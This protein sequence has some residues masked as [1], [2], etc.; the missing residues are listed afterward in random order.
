MP[1]DLE[2]LFGKLATTLPTATAWE[3]NC[4]FSAE[5]LPAAPPHLVT[6]RLVILKGDSGFHGP[7]GVSWR[8]DLLIFHAAKE[9][10]R[11]LALL[12]FS[13][14]F[15]PAPTEVTV[16]LRHPQSEITTLVVAYDD[17]ADQAR[18]HLPFGYH[19]RPHAF[20]YQPVDVTSRFPLLD[21]SRSVSDSPCFYLLM[22]DFSGGED[23]SWRRRNRVR[24]FGSD[25][26]CARLAELLLNISRPENT[27][28]EIAFEGEGG[29]RS[30]GP[31]SADA[32][33]VLP[34]SHAWAPEWWS[35]GLLAPEGG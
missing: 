21:P 19:I 13:V 24:G 33:L 3:G 22:T 26:G 30:V 16:A 15:H 8:A 35:S 20:N 29:Y 9:T 4:I 31:R 17:F 2:L 27:M 28:P 23:E 14:L 11:H 7:H 25:R 10:Y 6:D 18:D 34:G 1:C 32:R 5:S 12:I